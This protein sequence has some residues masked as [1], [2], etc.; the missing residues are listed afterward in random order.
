MRAFALLAFDECDTP[1]SKAIISKLAPRIGADVTVRTIPTCK[2]NREFIQK[3]NCNWYSYHE[4]K[5]YGGIHI[6]VNPV[7]SNIRNYAIKNVKGFL[8]LPKSKKMSHY[9]VISCLYGLDPN[10]DFNKSSDVV[11]YIPTSQ[12]L[13]DELLICSNVGI[14]IINIATNKGIKELINKY[15]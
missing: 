9:N 14:N 11:T 5:D 15:S 3:L 7:C 2:F 8:K 4:N 10:G 6:S 12:P 13:N 1:I